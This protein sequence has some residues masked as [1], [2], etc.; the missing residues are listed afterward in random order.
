MRVMVMGPWV[1]AKAEGSFRGAAALLDTKM[2]RNSNGGR[3]WEYVRVGCEQA[4]YLDRRH[5]SPAGSGQILKAHTRAFNK[6]F[7]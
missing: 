7:K 1:N 6:F 4:P 3:R 2:E 5:F